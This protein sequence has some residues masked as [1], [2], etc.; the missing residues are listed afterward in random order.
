LNLKHNIDAIL[1]M[2][3]KACQISSRSGG[4]KAV[5]FDC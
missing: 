4:E 5:H 3:E 1:S 2:A